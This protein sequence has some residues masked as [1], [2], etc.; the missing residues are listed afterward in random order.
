MVQCQ[1]LNHA[2]LAQTCSK[3]IWDR[4][5]PNLV[6]VKH[7]CVKRID[8]RVVLT[9]R[10]RRC[11]Q[12]HARIDIVDHIFCIEGTGS[13]KLIKLRQTVVWML[14]QH[15][16]HV[17]NNTRWSSQLGTKR[18]KFRLHGKCISIRAM[19]CK[20]IRELALVSNIP[21]G[22]GIEQVSVAVCSNRPQIKRR[23]IYDIN[24]TK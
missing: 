18:T 23:N 9:L 13:L 11:Q 19:P 24:W 14:K 12:A 8:P 2:M 15:A 17:V 22:N 20:C 4:H 5:A 16:A 3:R 7:D 1:L 10:R 21:E 6:V